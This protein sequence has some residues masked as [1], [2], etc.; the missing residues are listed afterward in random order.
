MTSRLDTSSRLVCLVAFTRD[1]HVH[2]LQ[3]ILPRG[4]CYTLS[5]RCGVWCVLHGAEFPGPVISTSYLSGVMYLSRG[6][7]LIGVLVKN[8]P[9]MQKQ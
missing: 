3:G 1:V 7:K 5:A 2:R 6:N 9:K 8:T 4:C